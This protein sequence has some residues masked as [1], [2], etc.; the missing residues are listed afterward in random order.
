MAQLAVA[1]TLQNGNVASGIIGALAADLPSQDPASTS[2]R[3][4]GM[5][6]ERS[7]NT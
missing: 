2:P 1:W 7:P 6:P 5:K 3:T 4:E